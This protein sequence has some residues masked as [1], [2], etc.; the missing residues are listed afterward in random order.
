LK[1]T[2]RKVLWFFGIFAVLC[3]V[4]I[5]GIGYA[6]FRSWFIVPGGA[7]PHELQLASEAGMPVEPDDLR[8]LK[9]VPDKENAAKIYRAFFP[10]IERSLAADTRLR[11]DVDDL[12]KGTATPAS[13]AR[14]K[15]FLVSERE[16]LS[17]IVAATKRPVCYF[18]YRYEDGAYLLLPELAQSKTAVRLLCARA[19]LAADR[20]EIDAA[21]G[22][23][24]AA[25]IV[26]RHIGTIPI[27]ISALVELAIESMLMEQLCHVLQVASKTK[28]NLDKIEL[29]LK[30][31]G[32]PIDLRIAFG[33]ELVLGRSTIHG[34]RSSKDMEALSGN[35]VRGRGMPIPAAVLR[36]F[37]AR[38]VAAWRKIYT[39]TPR[40][41]ND[42]PSTYESFVEVEKSLWVDE[43]PLN[44]MNVALF[45]V[46]NQSA[47]SI[48]RQIANRRVSAASIRLMK[49]KLETSRYPTSPPALG[50]DT[51]DPFDGK[52]L[53]Y[54]LEGSGFRIWSIDRDLQDNGGVR[55]EKGANGDLVRAFK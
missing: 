25:R 34:I 30:G 1:D 11:E 47:F 18:S 2:R 40:N 26:G 28:S 54:K 33:G 53:R 14:V 38:F 24:T 52:P 6:L 48:I 22:D 23:I 8:P 5:C 21:L 19:R 3:P 35:P 32:G 9:P 13:I 55:K 12:A 15:R 50:D 51:I 43:S 44:A 29:A 45:P 31:F 10:H 36:S 39:N 4:G 16:P 17:E 37:D 41:P 20:G 27:L 49:I 46:L 7:L 42:W